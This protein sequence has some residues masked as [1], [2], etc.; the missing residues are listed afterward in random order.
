MGAGEA[1]RERREE[2]L[3]KGGGREVEEESSRGG[4]R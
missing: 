2:G 4:R 3:M 1:V